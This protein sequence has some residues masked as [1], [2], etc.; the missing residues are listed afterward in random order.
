M[1][2]LPVK[3]W[4][5]CLSLLADPQRPF[6]RMSLP[7]GTPFLSPTLA[8]NPNRVFFSMVWQAVPVYHI[9]QYKYSMHI[10]IDDDVDLHWSSLIYNVS[11]THTASYCFIKKFSVLMTTALE[12][13]NGTPMGRAPGLHSPQRLEKKN[14]AQDL[15]RKFRAGSKP[16]SQV[17]NI[18]SPKAALQLGK[19]QLWDVQPGYYICY[20]CNNYCNG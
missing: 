4:L 8:G 2:K 7:V 9:S 15:L 3:P 16:N 14:R 6:R 10:Y 1:S 20:L 12:K 5:T 18:E 13:T 17:L 19:C 11:C